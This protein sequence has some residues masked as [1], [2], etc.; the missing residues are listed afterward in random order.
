[1]LGWV[2]RGWNRRLRRL[3]RWDA[4][5]RSVVGRGDGYQVVVGAPV[6]QEGK[7][8][9]SRLGW[10]LGGDESEDGL[11]VGE[12]D[13]LAMK[14]A[15]VL[16]ARFV[17][18]ERPYFDPIVDRN[19]GLITGWVGFEL[20]GFDFQGHGIGPVGLPLRCR[21]DGS[22]GESGDVLEQILDQVLQVGRGLLLEGIQQRE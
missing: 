11:S 20:S 13:Q 15:A 8:V 14:G 10:G 12:V 5:G 6:D 18:G 16:M 9:D 21:R 3:R 17:G 1:M 19:L 7:W 22:V 2:G 4:A